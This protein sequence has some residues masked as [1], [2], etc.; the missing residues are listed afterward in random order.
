MTTKNEL[1]DKDLPRK[2]MLPPAEDLG[3]Y[4]KGDILQ[5]A[6]YRFVLDEKY[7]SRSF[8][9]DVLWALNEAYYQCARIFDDPSPE[10]DI[11]GNYLFSVEPADGGHGTTGVSEKGYFVFCLVYI[12]LSVQA[13]LPESVNIFRNYLR[14]LLSGCPYYEKAEEY[15]RRI[16]GNNVPLCSDLA[17]KPNPFI[18]YYCKDIETVTDGF[19]LK[20]VIRILRRCRTKDYQ[21]AFL[22]MVENSFYRLNPREKPAS[23]KPDDIP[24]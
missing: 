8:R 11:F 5:Q 4:R 18:A 16:R 10:S 21:H 1:H 7:S 24:F 3:F 15:I 13:S 2:L 6:L 19:D 22:N 9:G 14:P 20:T 12:A 23:A 17:P